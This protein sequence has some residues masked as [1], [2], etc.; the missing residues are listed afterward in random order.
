MRTTRNRKMHTLTL[1]SP[2]FCVF[3]EKNSHQVNAIANS[4]D[5]VWYQWKGFNIKYYM[6][7]DGICSIY[8]IAGP[9]HPH[10][11]STRSLELPSFA[12]QPLHPYEGKR[13]CKAPITLIKHGVEGMVR[14]RLLKAAPVGL[15]VQV[16]HGSN[17]K[18]TK[19]KRRTWG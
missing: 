12:G 8:W 13:E 2:F 19:N 11:G 6:K 4:R 18:T 3:D 16:R 15:Q 14:H 10:L 7:D 9:P 1:T 5:G 17:P